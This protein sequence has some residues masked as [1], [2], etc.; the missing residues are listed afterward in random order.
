MLVYL[1]QLRPKKKPQFPIVE[2]KNLKTS[3]W[4]RHDRR[5]PQVL[6]PESP[7]RP[8]KGRP[9]TFSPE[10]NARLV[11][12][13]LMVLESPLPDR[14]RKREDE[15]AARPMKRISTRTKLEFASSSDEDELPS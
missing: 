12:L 11:R 2:R 3:A 14:K 7:I 5:R 4:R 10:T 15:E 9:M 8:K 1:R 6:E 13:G